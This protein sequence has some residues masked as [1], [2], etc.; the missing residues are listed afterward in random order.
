MANNLVGAVKTIDTA[1]TVTSESIPV[2]GFIW[3]NV[4]TSGDDLLVKDRSGNIVLS[5][6]GSANQPVNIMFGKHISFQGLTVV[7]IDSGILHIFS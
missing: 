2:L 3:S 4:G 1:G 5:L 7:T 6:K